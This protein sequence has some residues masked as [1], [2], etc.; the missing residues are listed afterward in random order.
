MQSEFSILNDAQLTGSV[1]GD[2][3]R[4]IASTTV[5][6]VLAS[7]LLASCQASDTSTQTPDADG[8]VATDVEVTT[9]ET[10][11][12]T[13]MDESAAASDTG[14]SDMRENGD[15]AMDDADAV[16]R[17]A[18]AH[19]HGLAQLALALDGQTLSIELES[20]LYNLLGFEHAPETDAQKETVKA[21]QE[22]L[23]DPSSLFRFNAGAACT[24]DATE[25]VALMSGET[26]EDHHDHDADHSHDDDHDH[27]EPEAHTDEAGPAHN[28]NNVILSYSFSCEKA[29]ELQWAELPIFDVFDNLETVDLVYLG[30]SQQMSASAASS[31]ERIALIK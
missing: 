24:P 5:A 15:M 17:E 6:S 9:T 10:V 13:D 20:P 1:L 14:E 21:A 11:A 26:D 27:D 7:I 4:A 19:I 23:S 31:S 29:D 3:V 22:S 18:G 12:M 25:P 30:P 8:L 28:H 16:V 2:R